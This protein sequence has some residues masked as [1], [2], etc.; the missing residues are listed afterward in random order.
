MILAL[1]L[2]P[3][4]SD[5]CYLLN[6]EA[7]RFLFRGVFFSSVSTM[8]SLSLR[9]FVPSLSGWIVN[10]GEGELG[11]SVPPLWLG[12]PAGT[13]W[14]VLKVV[15]PVPEAGLHISIDERLGGGVYGAPPQP[16]VRLCSL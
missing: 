14:H 12:H 10:Y 6:F 1:N 8:K 4:S 11:P 13:T 15:C 5:C 16:Y 3:G 2:P 9:L 7:A